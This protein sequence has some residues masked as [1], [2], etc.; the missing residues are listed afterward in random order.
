MNE[1]YLLWGFG[2]LALAALL[3]FIEVF[4]PSG[5]VIGLF[6]GVCA[7]A[8]VVFFFKASAMWG[9]SSIL[10]LLVMTPLMIS[11]ALKIWPN[12]PIGQRLILGSSSPDDDLPEPEQSDPLQDLIGATGVV[13]TDLRPVGMVQIEGERIEAIAQT[14]VIR[15]GQPVRITAIEDGRIKVRPVK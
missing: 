6:V 15:A 11:F 8:S 13:A 7:I 12:T 2:L 9:L 1:S 14:G 3:F 10:F 5:G 4:L